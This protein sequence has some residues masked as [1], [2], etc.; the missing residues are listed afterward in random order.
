MTS[1]AEEI[2]SVLR[3][4]SPVTEIRYEILCTYASEYVGAD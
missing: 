1:V 4:S 2:Q 3:M